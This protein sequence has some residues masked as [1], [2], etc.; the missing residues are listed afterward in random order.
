ML[1]NGWTKDVTLPVCNA[2]FQSLHCIAHLDEDITE[3]LPYL[4]AEWGGQQFITDPPSVT[5]KIHG[6]LIT[7]H[8]RT[9]AINALES[10]E[11]AESILDW[12]K[13]SIND[14]WARR[15]EL[16]PSYKKA[17]APLLLELL[18]RLPRSNCKRCG[19]PTCFVFATQIME[20]G[21]PPE[22]CLALGLQKRMRLEEYLG[23]FG[24]S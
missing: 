15:R 6:R 5:F 14:V 23:Q 19:Q 12:L 13:K 11:Q 3:A 16:Q 22:D 18:K 17:A 7:L 9:I 20:G 10:A 1:L 8:P 4:N 21:R 2:D 24:L